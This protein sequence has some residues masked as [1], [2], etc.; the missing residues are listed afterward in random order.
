MNT[1]TLKIRHF[2]FLLLG[3]VGVTNYSEAA[4]INASGCSKS[5]V[6]SAVDKAS[7]GDTVSLP[8][9]SG[10][11][12]SKVTIPG[13][14]G[15]TLDGNGSTIT[16]AVDVTQNDSTT[17]RITNFKF[18]STKAVYFHG[19]PS[20][21]TAR[22]D[23]SKFSGGN[24]AILVE[25]E[26]NAP[27]LIDHNEFSGGGASEMIH[28]YGTWNDS[29]W[30][31]DVTPGGPTMVFIEDNT[32]NNTGASGSP[33]YFWGT[34]A[35]QSYY[36]ARTVFRHNTLN[37]T[38]VDQHG[39]AGMVG[40]RWWEI[41]EN[42]FNV[43]QNGNQS[44]YMA[45]RAGSG[46]IF[47]NHKTGANNDGAGS[48]ELVEEDSGYPA[49]YQIGRGKNQ[50]QDAAYVWGNDSSMRVGSNSSNVQ[51]GRDFHESE[52]PNYKP[53]TYPHPLVTG[54]SGSTGSNGSKGSTGSTDKL[55]P[56]TN[57]RAF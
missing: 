8:N 39:T 14:K 16:G 48:I 21:A 47:N 36:S 41:Y 38:Q 34:S 49:L 30:K 51:K 37:M 43:V 40:A 55:L 11:W 27:V 7:S 52:K 26:G 5:D 42:T 25:L 57:L 18:N 17:T 50:S 19:S 10:N 6:Q 32:F 24:T 54:A 9:C 12:D 33:A 46:V 31:D 23:H 1:S 3:T 29:G 28:N 2:A 15:I 4:T 53:Y 20:S 35:V 56:P 13:S 45:I 44:N 22:L